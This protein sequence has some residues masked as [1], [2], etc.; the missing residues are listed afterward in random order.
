[1]QTPTN[2]HG[3]FDSRHRIHLGDAAELMAGIPAM[4]GFHPHRSMVL[5]AVKD[6]GAT[7]GPT[8]RHDL[9][10]AGEHLDRRAADGSRATQEMLDVIGYLAGYCAAENIPAVM[11]VF[12]DDRLDP[13]ARGPHL[14]DV[15]AL[16][17]ELV[18]TL[19]T[20]GVQLFAALAAPEIADAAP[21]WSLCG[22][23]RHGLMSDPASSPL[24]VARVLDGYS[25]RRCR[26]ELAATIAPGPESTVQAVATEIARRERGTTRS[27]ADELSSVLA[28]LA[29]APY[30]TEL[31]PADLARIAIAIGHVHIRDALLALTLGDDAGYVEEFW[32]NVCR[33]LPRRERAIAATLVA[34][35][36]YVRGDGP[37]ARTAIDAALD[38]DGT[39]RLAQLLDRSL[40]AGAGPELV[41]EVAESGFACARDCGVRLPGDPFGRR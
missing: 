20:L 24:T 36:A 31:E 16:V 10:L 8:M 38:A 1:M 29:R 6:G 28:Y 26:G 34:F 19:N 5:I 18:G 33:V 41:R 14:L 13:V 39:H 2:S 11:A 40:T 30:D 9:V 25:V 23:R 3:N 35:S 22:P 27:R 37:M 7:V 32:A 21:W 12:V 15:E 4:L 17:S